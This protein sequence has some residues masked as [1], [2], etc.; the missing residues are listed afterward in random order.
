MFSYS[1]GF[2]VSPRFFKWVLV[3]TRLAGSSKGLFFVWLGVVPLWVGF[4]IWLIGQHE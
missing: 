4:P 2:S 3:S 1:F